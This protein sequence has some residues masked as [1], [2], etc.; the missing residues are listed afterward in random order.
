[1]RCSDRRV[2]AGSRPLSHIIFFTLYRRVRVL[3]PSP[4]N[5]LL[6]VLHALQAVYAGVLVY[7]Q[8]QK[9]SKLLL[10]AWRLQMGLAE[11]GSN[12]LPDQPLA[13]RSVN[14]W[15]DKE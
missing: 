3:P 5:G 7:V 8:K 2:A 12:S 10:R 13:R 6:Q 15:M 14:L 1:V 9:K 11:C 4:V